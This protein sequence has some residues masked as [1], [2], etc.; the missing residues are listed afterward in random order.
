[1]LQHDFPIRTPVTDRS[2]ISI[3]GDISRFLLHYVGPYSTPRVQF[4]LKYGP[5]HIQLTCIS[6][7][8]EKIM[9]AHKR[10]NTNSPLKEQYHRPHMRSW[11][12]NFLQILSDT[13]KFAICETKW[14]R[15]VQGQ[16]L[17]L[18][19]AVETSLAVRGVF[20]TSS[21]R[22]SEWEKSWRRIQFEGIVYQPKPDRVLQVT[23]WTFLEANSRA[24][25][26]PEK[27]SLRGTWPHIS[28]N[29]MNV[30]PYKT[31]TLTHKLHDVMLN[32]PVHPKPITKSQIMWVWHEFLE[33]RIR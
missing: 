8:Y 16:T 21:S 4:F 9:R 13:F 12:A 22:K 15:Q 7:I 3:F 25:I 17:I 19:E 1:M 29:N 31:S 20:N 18:T 11:S 6:Q 10:G 30:S 33:A 24:C 14:R 23:A 26:A 32:N 28:F 2:E 5:L 27:V